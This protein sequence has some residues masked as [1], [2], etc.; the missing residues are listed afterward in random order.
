MSNTTKTTITLKYPV[1]Y[2][3]RKITE[4]QMR[5]ATA[6]DMQLANKQGKDEFERE[7]N[8][9]ASLTETEPAALK[10]LDLADYKEIQK[11]F[12]DFFS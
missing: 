2:Q 3:G 1:E 10:L 6:G 9:F 8:L 7:I 12:E 4:L 5:R 11:T